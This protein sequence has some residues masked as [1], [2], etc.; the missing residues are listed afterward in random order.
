[1]GRESRRPRTAFTREI[2]I[3]A[4]DEPGGGLTRVELAS[5]F[6]WNTKRGYVSLTVAT[7]EATIT[8]LI[9]ISKAREIVGMWHGAIEAA[10]SDEL[11]FLF[12][13]QNVGLGDEQAG[14]ALL[15]FR[16]LRQG[17]T[18]VVYPQ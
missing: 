4:A 18:D 13:T 5:M 16:K 6:G 11:L 9:D 17:T 7:D 1:M 2:E 8:T 15:D 3:P 10:I 12:L 14:R